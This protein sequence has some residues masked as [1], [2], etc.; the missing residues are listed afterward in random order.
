MKTVWS[1]NSEK[2]SDEYQTLTNMALH[3]ETVNT[4]HLGTLVTLGSVL[5]LPNAKNL[6]VYAQEE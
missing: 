3:K 6:M 1:I 2:Y 4:W 5:M